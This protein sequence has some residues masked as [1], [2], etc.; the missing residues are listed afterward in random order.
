MFFTY[1]E[2]IMLE[3]NTG[4]PNEFTDSEH[5]WSEHNF[6]VKSMLAMTL[7]ERPGT[8]ITLAEEPL[9]ESY[10]NMQG[11][12]RKAMKFAPAKKIH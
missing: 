12:R 11:E 4:K 8:G 10:N 7:A 5:F 2:N 1:M 3:T 9:Y 6:H